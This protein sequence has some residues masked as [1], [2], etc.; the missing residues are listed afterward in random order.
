MI[1]TIRTDNPKAE[2]TLQD[3]PNVIDT[4]TWQAHRRLAETIH[5]QMSGLLQRHNKDWRA[6][7]G[8]VVYKGPGSFTGLRIGLSVANALAEGLQVPIVGA[9]GETWRLE[10]VQAL[11]SEVSGDRQVLPYYGAEVHITPPKH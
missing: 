1:L 10:G 9:T 3:G 5:R 8:I 2:L 11:E 6:I 7:T 4:L